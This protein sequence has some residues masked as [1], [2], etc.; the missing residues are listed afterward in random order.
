[1]EFHSFK[2]IRRAQK[3]NYLCGVGKKLCSPFCARLNFPSQLVEILS[4]QSRQQ[5]LIQTVA[6]LSSY[7][8]STIH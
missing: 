8:K 7:A 1:M 4:L 6:E 5:Q 3:M 2:H